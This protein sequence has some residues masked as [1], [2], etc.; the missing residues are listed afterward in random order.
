MTKPRNTIRTFALV[1]VAITSLFVLGMIAWYT[2]ILTGRDWC[3]RAMG[4]AQL[5]SR[6]ESAIASCYT[7]LLEQ[8]RA[9]AW[10]S[11]IFVGI[12][13]LCLLVLMVIVVAG[14]EVSFKAS[15]SGLQGHIG[16][17]VDPK[18]AAQFV[19][20]E[21]QDAADRVPTHPPPIDDPEGGA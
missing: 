14:G 15:R 2:V 10:N 20:D 1:C 11:H 16:R 13:A 7:L 3:S 12:I 18:V 21:A 5:A 8:V 19:A 17:E 6:P 9:L 4:A